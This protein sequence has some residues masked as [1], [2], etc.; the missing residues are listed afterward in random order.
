MRAQ[1]SGRL[2]D[3]TQHIYPLYQALLENYKTVQQLFKIFSSFSL[4]YNF[5]LVDLKCSS[6][7]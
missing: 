5:S 2:D 7:L 3:S 4:E 6:K 1:L